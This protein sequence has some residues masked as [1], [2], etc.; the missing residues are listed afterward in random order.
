MAS[1]AS[2]DLDDDVQ[3]MAIERQLRQSKDPQP[4]YLP[5][6]IR[7]SVERAAAQRASEDEAA[8]ADAPAEEAA[9]APIAQAASPA[10][11]DALGLRRGLSLWVCEHR[12]RQRWQLRVLVRREYVCW[13]HVRGCGVSGGAAAPAHE[14]AKSIAEAVAPTGVKA[15]SCWPD[16]GVVGQ[17]GLLLRAQRSRK[18]RQQHLLIG[19]LQA[20]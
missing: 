2:V 1:S 12:E 7:G 4:V 6:H 8:A 13:L 5:Q 20:D 17:P 16:C 14:A 11:K 19:K 10:G 15:C 18:Q 3:K 9:P